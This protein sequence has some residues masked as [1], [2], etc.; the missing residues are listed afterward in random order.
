MESFISSQGEK[1]KNICRS[2]LKDLEPK[3]INMNF[4]LTS[5]ERKE[6]SPISLNDEVVKLR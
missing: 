1:H 2:F 3:D 6:A 4:I 5:L